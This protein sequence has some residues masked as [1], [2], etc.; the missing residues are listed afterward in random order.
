MQEIQVFSHP[1][2]RTQ[3]EAMLKWLTTDTLP[4]TLVEEKGFQDFCKTL[5]PGYTKVTQ[6]TLNRML[7]GTVTNEVKDIRYFIR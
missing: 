3:A 5:D 7:V 1:R 4:L 6:R 2:Q